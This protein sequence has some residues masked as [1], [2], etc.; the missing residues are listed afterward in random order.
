[1]IRSLDS[2][3]LVSQFCHTLVAD[4]SFR[5]VACIV[6]KI[7]YGYSIKDNDPFTILTEEVGKLIHNSGPSASTPVDFFPWREFIIQFVSIHMKHI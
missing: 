3:H 2:R 6:V 5:S 4:I 7:A 1:M